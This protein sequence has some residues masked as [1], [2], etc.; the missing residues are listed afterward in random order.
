MRNIF[1]NPFG[2]L[3]LKVILQGLTPNNSLLN[4]KEGLFVSILNVLAL[5][6]VLFELK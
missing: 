1:T 3:Y 2:V 6:G 4:F 5:K